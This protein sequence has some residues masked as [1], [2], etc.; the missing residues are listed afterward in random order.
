MSG[1]YSWLA[2]FDLGLNWA[3]IIKWLPKLAQG[4]I[5]TLELVA[6]AVIAGLSRPAGSSAVVEG[7]ELEYAGGARR[8][9]PVEEAD[10]IWRYGADR[11]A[12]TLDSLEPGREQSCL[13]GLTLE[14]QPNPSRPAE[15]SA[16]S[17]RSVLSIP[18][19][20]PSEKLTGPSKAPTAMS[21]DD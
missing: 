21:G 11:T 9:V 17:S 12:V 4:A 15:R 16:K 3:V 2:H 6:I 1:D 5:L 18:V 19:I 10:R 8:L 14:A 13:L 20:L 7:I